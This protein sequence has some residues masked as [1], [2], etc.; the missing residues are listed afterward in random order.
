LF[1]NHYG[2]GKKMSKPE[3]CK[4]LNA[5]LLIDDQHDYA[6]QCSENGIKSILFGA[7]PWNSQP[8]HKILHNMHR[9]IS[10]YEVED[11]IDRLLEGTE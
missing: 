2:Q 6:R 9:A 1:G 4:L 8:H 3:M 10:W 5:V 11:A 7:Y